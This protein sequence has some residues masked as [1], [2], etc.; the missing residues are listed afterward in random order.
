MRGRDQERR[1][2]A[3]REGEFNRPLLGETLSRGGLGLG[4]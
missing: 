2:R 3:R 1:R 4:G